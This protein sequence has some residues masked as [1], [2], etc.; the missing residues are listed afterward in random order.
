MTP[1]EI[2][3]KIAQWGW[4]SKYL[5]DARKRFDKLAQSEGRDSSYFDPDELV[6]YTWQQGWGD[7]SCGFGGIGGQMM[8]S[9]TTVVIGNYRDLLVYH[10]RFAYS[11]SQ[12]TDVFWHHV[13]AQ[14][15]DG[16]D[17]AS[18]KKYSQIEGGVRRYNNT[19]WA[20]KAPAV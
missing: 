2:E 14:R 7:T 11:V 19:I 10:G 9:Q 3:Y 20:E 5:E 16:Y 18:S 6:V 1:E 17:R 12:P 8:T 4:L 15:L 13:T